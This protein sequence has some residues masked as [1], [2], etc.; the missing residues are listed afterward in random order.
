MI[1]I[2]IRTKVH[3]LTVELGVQKQINS[4]LI[5][6]QAFLEERIMKLEKMFILSKIE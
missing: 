3:N 4:Q 2:D 1:P 6:N 5:K